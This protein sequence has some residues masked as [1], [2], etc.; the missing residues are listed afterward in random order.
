VSRESKSKRRQKR[1]RRALNRVKRREV[2]STHPEQ[3]RVRT[4]FSGKARSGDE[5]ELDVSF[6]ETSVPFDPES[7]EFSEE[8]A[9]RHAAVG[10]WRESGYPTEGEG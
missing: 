1:R 6:G 5:A 8:T 3:V 7:E 9:R 4:S 10:A 2:L